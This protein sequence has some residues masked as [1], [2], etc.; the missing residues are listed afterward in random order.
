MLKK[1]GSEVTVFG[2]DR[3]RTQGLAGEFGAA[4]ASL[5]AA[6]FREYDIV[7]NATPLGTK[8]P[9]E[10]KTIATADQLA[11]TKLVYDLIYNPAETTL[12]VEAKNAGAAFIGGLEM[13][14][15]Q[16]AKQFEI[17]TGQEAPI[18]A[19]GRAVRQRLEI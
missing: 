14:V 12:A 19:M 10:H 1:H 4:K 18:D 2:R 11:S 5:S 17:W 6:D 8:G 13:L 16:G 3:E 9:N 7:V 15:N